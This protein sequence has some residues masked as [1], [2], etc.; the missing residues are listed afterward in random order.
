LIVVIHKQGLGTTLAFII[1][2]NEYQLDSHVPLSVAGAQADHHTFKL[3]ACN[4]LA[5]TRFA[6]LK[7]CAHQGFIVL[8]G[9]TDNAPAGWTA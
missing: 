6:T 8:W 7:C 2:E 9:C 3:L 4:T 1:Q 5:L